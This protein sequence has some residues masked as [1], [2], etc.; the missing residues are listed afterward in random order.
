MIYCHAGRPMNH[1]LKLQE[2]N[3][4]QKA[5]L[6]KVGEEINQFI[7]HLNS[8]KFTGTE[9]DGARKDWISTA[10]VINWLRE[11]RAGLS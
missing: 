9:S 1:I 11:V 7:I 4:E 8:A 3:R 2:E 5:K 6:E 10:D